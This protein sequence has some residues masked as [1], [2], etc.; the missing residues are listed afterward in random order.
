MKDFSVT[1]LPATCATGLINFSRFSSS[2]RGL[3]PA[4]CLIKTGDGSQAFSVVIDISNQFW[5]P[6]ANG[7]LMPAGVSNITVPVCAQN[8]GMQGNVAAGTITMIASA[9]PGI[10]LVTNPGGLTNGRNAESDSAFR[11]RFQ[12]FLAS[13]SRA[14]EAAVGYA[15]SCVQQGLT[16]VIL[17][18][19]DASGAQRPG[20]FIVTVD[21]GSGNPPASLLAS[22]YSA[23][24]AIRPIGCTFAVQPPIL[25][26]VT[27]MLTLVLDSTVQPAPVISIVEAAITEYINA[28]PIGML[29]SITRIAQVAYRASNLIDNINNIT[30]NGEALDLTTAPVCVIK[31]A[32]VTVN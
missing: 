26:P 15:V 5:S 17:E 13:R 32:T 6:A 22:V 28:L 10:D 21:D 30:I 31:A 2:V 18:N 16:Y 1:R 14:T 20:S 24:D 29:L 19:V 9:L 11:G 27:V 4:G 23:I 12:N 3:V 8:L 7:Y 25:T